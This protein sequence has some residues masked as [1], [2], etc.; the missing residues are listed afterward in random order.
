MTQNIKYKIIL[1]R[2]IKVWWKIITEKQVGK[3]KEKLKIGRIAIRKSVSIFKIRKYFFNK[4]LYTSELRKYSDWVK[5]QKKNKG[6][7]HEIIYFDWISDK[8]LD[9]KKKML[10]FVIFF[11]LFS[12]FFLCFSC[13]FLVFD[14]WWETFFRSSLILMFITRYTYSTNQTTSSDVSHSHFNHIQFIYFNSIS[15]LSF[16]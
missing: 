3:N 10:N 4:F 6:K 8:N 14:K 7:S 11:Y 15:F 1:K 2:R 16:F 12:C 5:C 13:V 9:E